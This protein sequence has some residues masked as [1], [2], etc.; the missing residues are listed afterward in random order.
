MLES[1]VEAGEERIGLGVLNGDVTFVHIYISVSLSLSLSPSIY[2]S[3]HT[4]RRAGSFTNAKLT[5]SLYCMESV[6]MCAHSHSHRF[7]CPELRESKAM[8]C[9]DGG[10]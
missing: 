7:R 4:T 6:S 8:P 9:G 2:L 5:E 3:L 1:R 10:R